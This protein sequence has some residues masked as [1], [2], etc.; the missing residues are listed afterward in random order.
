MTIK[1]SISIAY[2]SLFFI[3]WL[4]CGNNHNGHMNNRMMGNG[5]MGSGDMMGEQQGINSD[6][7]GSAGQCMTGQGQTP[8]GSRGMQQPLTMDL[9]RQRAEEYLQKTGN[10]SLR[11][12]KGIERKNDFEFPLIRTSDGSHAARLLVNKSTGAVN[13]QR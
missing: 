4:S 5:Q 7:M 2:L 8:S 9:A 1:K 13:S 10:E 3:L 6:S 11:I 12:G